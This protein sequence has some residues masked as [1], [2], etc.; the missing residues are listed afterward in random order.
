MA[1][2]L[3]LLAVSYDADLAYIHHTAF[4]G[5]V[6][7]AA[8]GIL[9]IFEKHSIR[10]GLVVDLGCGSGV[11]ARILTD[12]GY[13]VL[14]I[15]ISP[16]MLRIAR[17][18]ASKARFRRESLLEAKLPL[19]SAVT[20]LGE[21]VNYLFDPK[22]NAKHLERLF[23]RV[24]SALEPGGVFVFDVAGPERSADAAAQRFFTGDDWA[25]LLAIE[26]K[27]DVLTRKMT[28]FRKIGM[29]YRRSE[30][31]HKVRLYTPD[32][33]LRTLKRVGFARVELLDAYGDEKFPQGHVGF[34][35]VKS[36]AIFM[37]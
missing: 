9:K 36:S 29:R 1:N 20:A 11:W 21:C 24:H 25:L 22:N 8:P 5:F 27:K 30:E 17:R 26:R 10:D 13:E 15:D 14:G 23:R 16:E 4:T 19:C 3:R 33:V 31:V 2:C 28:I 12:H 7:S 18:E 37:V 32:F 34:L 35:A 6:R